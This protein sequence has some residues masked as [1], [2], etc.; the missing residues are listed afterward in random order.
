MW[1]PPVRL[2]LLSS[3][4]PLQHTVLRPRGTARSPYRPGRS[5]RL[6]Y[7]R[8]QC[9]VLETVWWTAAPLRGRRTHTDSSPHSSSRETTSTLLQASVSPALSMRALLFHTVTRAQRARRPER[10]LSRCASLL[11]L[12][13]WTRR[14]PNCG[15]PLVTLANRTATECAVSSRT[16]LRTLPAF[17][18]RSFSAQGVRGDTTRTRSAQVGRGYRLEFASDGVVSSGFVRSRSRC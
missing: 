10:S 13:P 14:Q 4:T 12:R 17:T 6:R 18:P 7:L 1:F 8:G 9:C 15:R 2:A 3:V 16:S 11:G 5:A